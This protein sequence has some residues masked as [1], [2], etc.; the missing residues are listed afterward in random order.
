MKSIKN[1][2]NKWNYTPFELFP[3]IPILAPLGFFYLWF[4]NKGRKNLKEL[5]IETKSFTEEGLIVV[6]KL[7][8]LVFLVTIITMLVA[9]IYH[10]LK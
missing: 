6:L 3:F 2:P 1:N 8:A 5:R 10:S 4:K 9:T 7:C